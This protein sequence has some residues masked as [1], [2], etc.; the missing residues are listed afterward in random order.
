MANSNLRSYYI[1]KTLN[2]WLPHCQTIFVCFHLQN[3]ALVIRINI[4]PY[5][6][7]DKEIPVPSNISHVESWLLLNWWLKI[8]PTESCL[9]NKRQETTFIMTSIQVCALNSSWSSIIFSGYHTL[10]QTFFPLWEVKTC[11][12]VPWIYLVEKSPTPPVV[13][14]HK[15][16]FSLTADY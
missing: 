16:P 5:A 4:K 15:S 10:F 11:L 7:I 14:S 6:G 13:S 9:F 1:W 2:Y 8:F 3:E 12:V